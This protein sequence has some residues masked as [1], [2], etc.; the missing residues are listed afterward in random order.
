MNERRGYACYAFV[1]LR[2]CYTAGCLL[3]SIVVARNI[4][5]TG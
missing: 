3:S 4:E 2:E 1:A 5:L